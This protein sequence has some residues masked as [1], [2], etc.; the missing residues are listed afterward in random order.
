MTSAR[1]LRQGLSRGLALV[2]AMAMLIM[3]LL[4]FVD[5][6][7]RYGFN[8]SVFGASEMIEWLMIP[9]VFAGFAQ[10]TTAGAHIRVS[11]FESR[12]GKAGRV[13][14][15]WFS[16]GAYL[17]MTGAL[18]VLAAEAWHSGRG[19]LVL[20]LPA[21]TY[22]GTALVLSLAGVLSLIL[23]MIR[24]DPGWWHPETPE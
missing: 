2:A 17:L 13:A 11:L 8:K 14:A 23:M 6:V 10:I 24:P 21:W 22:A 20:N 7:G 15:A 16:L 18:W 9:V 4:T 19:T 3:I 5:V 12:L 1:G